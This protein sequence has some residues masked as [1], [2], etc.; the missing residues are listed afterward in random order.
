MSNREP[1]IDEL[2]N[3]LTEQAD[4]K[5]QGSNICQNV[6]KLLIQVCIIR[7]LFDQR[8]DGINSNHLFNVKRS[9]TKHNKGRTRNS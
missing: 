6:K 3:N 7:T 9:Y 1:V 4:N 5:K 8:N 2:T